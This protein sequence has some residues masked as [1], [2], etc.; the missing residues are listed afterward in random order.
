LARYLT[1]SIREAGHALGAAGYA[2]IHQF[3]DQEF[4]HLTESYLPR[5]LRSTWSRRV[6]ELKSPDEVQQ[7]GVDAHIYKVDFGG[8]DIHLRKSNSAH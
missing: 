5:E 6:D 7:T 8:N 1:D 4:F 2:V 3:D